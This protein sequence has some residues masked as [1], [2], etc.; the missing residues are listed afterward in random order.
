MDE[1]NVY[2]SSGVLMNLINLHLRTLPTNS[3][4]FLPRFMIMIMQEM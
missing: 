3:K 2:K 1:I 4:V